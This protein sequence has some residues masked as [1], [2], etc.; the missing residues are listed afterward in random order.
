MFI[1]LQPKAAELRQIAAMHRL[2]RPLVAKKGWQRI[3]NITLQHRKENAENV[4]IERR[5][6]VRIRE[7]LPTVR[8]PEGVASVSDNGTRQRTCNPFDYPGIAA[9]IL[10]HLSAIAKIELFS[11]SARSTAGI[12]QNLNSKWPVVHQS[13]HVTIRLS[14]PDANHVRKGCATIAFRLA[15]SSLRTNTCIEGEPAGSAP[16]MKISL[17]PKQCA[18]R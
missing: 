11:G 8:H 5:F 12:D 2:P 16:C 13:V 18:L 15:T 6:R 4:V 3:T 17:Y 9:T 14:P 7:S 10:A 1:G